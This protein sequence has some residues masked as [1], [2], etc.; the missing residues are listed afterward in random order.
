MYQHIII[1]FEDYYFKILGFLVNYAL[2]PVN[3]SVC[4][5]HLPTT[6]NHIQH[7][8]KQTKQA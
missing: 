8:D 6:F 3:K 7:Q 4:N 5:Q 1:N 2:L